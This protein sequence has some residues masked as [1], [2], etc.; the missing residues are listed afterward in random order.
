MAVTSKKI[1]IAGGGTGGHIYPGLAI[2]QAIKKEDPSCEVHFVGTKHGLE[3]KIIPQNN[4]KLHL[5]DIGGLKN[6]SFLKKIF[7]FL[8]FP[9]AFLQ[10]VSLLLKYRPA[11]V[12]GVGGYSSGPF[13]LTASLMGF[14]TALFESNA[15]PGITNRILSRFV[16]TS[17]TLFEELRQYLKSKK[18]LIYGFPVRGSMAPSPARKDS[19]LKVLIFGGSQGARGINMTVSQAINKY[20]Q[21][22]KEIEFVHQTGK[23]DFPSYKDFYKER[24]N[25]KCL[26]Y[27]DPIKDYYD[28][29]DLVVCRAGASTLS[30]LSACGKAAILVPFPFAADNHQ[31]KNAE[32]LVRKNAARMC[33]QK[34]FTP[35]LFM[36]L[37][38]EFKNNRDEI[39][40]LENNIKSLYIPNAA[41]NIAKDILFCE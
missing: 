15:A 24:P 31:Q 4:F 29:A 13:V 14:K 10:C 12:F 32:S 41:T 1:F 20:P 35:E 21:E 18:V 16:Q 17:F 25:V 28:W 2:A 37:V 8:K 26:E 36:K 34:D 40:A 22:L 30:E 7:V 39:A 5:I 27:L 6:T 11:F 3:N 23:L 38:L 33:L 19:G 9:L